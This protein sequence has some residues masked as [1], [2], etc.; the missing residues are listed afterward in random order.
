MPFNMQ[1]LH[2][3]LGMKEPVSGE[4]AAFFSRELRGRALFRAAQVRDAARPVDAGGETHSPGA[5][6][7]LRSGRVQALR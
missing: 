1:R 2:G 4:A 5:E 6:V 3:S 7:Q